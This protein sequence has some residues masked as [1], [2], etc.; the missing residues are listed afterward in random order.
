MPNYNA[1]VTPK[2]GLIL[3]SAQVLDPFRKLRS[4]R[5]WYKGMDI[6]PGHET[7]Y[8]TQYQDGFL[9]YVEK[10]YCAKHRWMSVLKP[11]NVLDIN[12]IP[13]ATAS[14]FVKSLFDP[15]DLSSDDE[16]C[17]TLES[18]AETTPRRSER[19][20]RLLTAARLYLNSPP[21]LP[22]NWG[23]VNPNLND[24]HSYPMEI[25]STFWL[26][27]I[28]NCGASKR[29]YCQSTPI[30]PMWHPTYSLL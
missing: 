14:G 25:G 12:Y 28:T 4:F 19:A 27:D 26:L 8:T 7:S 29:I 21:D 2:T 9:K 15:Y 10:W 13:S 22:N 11:E 3:I 23:Q 6:D 24:N 30:S 5:K 16:E 1:E 18:G 20:A 17:L